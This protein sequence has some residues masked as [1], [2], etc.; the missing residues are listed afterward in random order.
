MD[1]TTEAA[2]EVTGTALADATRRVEAITK[3]AAS[4][5]SV[6][7]SLTD[8]VYTLAAVVGVGLLAIAALAFLALR[9]LFSLM[10]AAQHARG[11]G[12]AGRGGIPSRSQ[13]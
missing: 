9:R 5:E 7:R 6:V 2:R 10:A 4:H 11:G 13:V 3:R 1:E 8:N 12:G